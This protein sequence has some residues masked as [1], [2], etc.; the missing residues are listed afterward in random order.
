MEGNL[1]FVLL[2]AVGTLVGLFFIQFFA[3]PS[4]GN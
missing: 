2:S 1:K 4:G 3:G